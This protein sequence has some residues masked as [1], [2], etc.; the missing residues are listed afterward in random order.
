MSLDFGV[1]KDLVVV[2][3]LEGLVAKEMNLVVLLQES[4]TIRLV[5]A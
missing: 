2:A 4:Q 1:I 3:A 5:P